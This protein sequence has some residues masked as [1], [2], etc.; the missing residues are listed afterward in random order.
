MR[1]A[2]T[3]RLSFIGLVLA[4]NASETPR[5]GSGGA[6]VT[7]SNRE[8]LTAA[9]IETRPADYSQ[10]NNKERTQVPKSNML[11]SLMKLVTENTIR[12]NMQ[13]DTQNP[14]RVEQDNSNLI[15]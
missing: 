7:P 4:L 14:V 1:Y 10:E 12:N 3:P 8:V 9:T 13:Y 11:P 15:T 2:P 6:M 5:I